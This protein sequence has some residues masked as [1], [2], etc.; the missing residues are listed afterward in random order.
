MDDTTLTDAEYERKY[1]FSRDELRIVKE[2]S[3]YE[4]NAQEYGARMR[5]G[6]TTVGLEAAAKFLERQE[7][8]GYNQQ[9]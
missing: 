5:G 7:V 2:K 4:K 9:L 3:L 8:R 1:D 6:H